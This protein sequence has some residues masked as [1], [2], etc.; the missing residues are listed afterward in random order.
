MPPPGQERLVGSDATHAWL[1]VWCG[2]DL[3]LDLDP[4]NG[5]LGSTDLITL[6]WGRDYDDVS[7]MRGVIIG[8]GGQN[9]TVEVDVAPAT[10]AAEMTEMAQAPEADEQ[11]QTQSQS[12]T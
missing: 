2:G 12:Q 7:P 10:D 6:A 5:A 1:S 3:W 4:T 11:S 8:G 9:L